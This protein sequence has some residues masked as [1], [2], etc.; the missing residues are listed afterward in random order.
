M[1]AWTSSP[2]ESVIYAFEASETR[3]LEITYE[4]KDKAKDTPVLN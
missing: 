1:S 3:D 4:Q 2:T